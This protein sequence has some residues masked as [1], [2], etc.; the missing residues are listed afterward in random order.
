MRTRFPGM[1]RLTIMNFH[2]LLTTL[3][4]SQA[5]LAQGT[6]FLANRV[7]V[8]GVDAPLTDVDGTTRLGSKFWAQLAVGD[9]ALGPFA[10]VGSPVSLIDH[11]ETG[12]PTGYFVGGTGYAPFLPGEADRAVSGLPA[13]TPEGDGMGRRSILGQHCFPRT[14]WI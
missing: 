10:V 6:I 12:E 11:P 8:D 1:Y 4:L 2:I 3:L 7:L 14:R 9:D 13:Q 5:A